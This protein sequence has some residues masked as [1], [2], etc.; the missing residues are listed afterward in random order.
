M[1]EKATK[2]K[3]NTKFSYI[4]TIACMLYVEEKIILI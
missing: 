1:E 4:Y 2:N 3:L